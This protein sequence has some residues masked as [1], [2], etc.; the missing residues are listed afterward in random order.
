MTPT[1]CATVEALQM[2]RPRTGRLR[3]LWL[4]MGKHPQ[5]KEMADCGPRRACHAERGLW[6][7]KSLRKEELAKGSFMSMWNCQVR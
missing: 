4:R 2:N 7:A 3:R 5:Q 6:S 1:G